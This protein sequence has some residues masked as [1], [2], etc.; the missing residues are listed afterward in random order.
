MHISKNRGKRLMETI[1]RYCKTFYA[2]RSRN[3]IK[4]DDE[5]IQERWCVHVEKF[6][7]KDNI[8]CEHFNI[9]SMFW[10]DDRE[11]YTPVVTCLTNCP[12]ACNGNQR[13]ELIE[14]VAG[15][16]FAYQAIYKPKKEKR[17]IDA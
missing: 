16:N 11:Q 10:C 5:T 4:K 15:S 17:L 3:L 14:I 8:S 13:E 12:D 1:C 7:T 9:I 6:V 2:S